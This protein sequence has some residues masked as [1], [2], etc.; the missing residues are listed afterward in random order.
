MP[1]P[2]YRDQRG[3]HSLIPI[4]QYKKRLGWQCRLFLLRLYLRYS[5]DWMP[6][7]IIYPI[8]VGHL[9]QDLSLDPPHGFYSF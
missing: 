8:L 7:R 1:S 9:Y 6:V 2:F 3:Q 5:L 4:P